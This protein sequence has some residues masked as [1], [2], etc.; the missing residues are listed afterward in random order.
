MTVKSCN[1]GAGTTSAQLV[2]TLPEQG[3]ILK[4]K[5]PQVAET[6]SKY[7]MKDTGYT[8]KTHQ[9]KNNILQK[10]TTLLSAS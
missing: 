1:P 2:V 7:L 8:Q 6:T 3:C 5:S 4:G 10:Q 9:E